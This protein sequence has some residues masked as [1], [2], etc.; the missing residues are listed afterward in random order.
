MYR[1]RGS[2]LAGGFGEVGFY[3]LDLLGSSDKSIVHISLNPPEDDDFG[4]IDLWT[5][6]NASLDVWPQ[7]L[8]S[9]S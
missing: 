7:A 4:H 3:T 2:N 9:S 8:Q 1:I 5:A 6:D